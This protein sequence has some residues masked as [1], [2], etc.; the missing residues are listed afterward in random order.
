[1]NYVQVFAVKQTKVQG[2]EGNK[3]NGLSDQTTRIDEENEI[4]IFVK[5]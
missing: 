5:K 1:M 2:L 4:I 3:Q